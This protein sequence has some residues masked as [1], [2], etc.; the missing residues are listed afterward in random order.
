M[1]P[2]QFLDLVAQAG[3]L[4]DAELKTARA[5][6]ASSGAKLRA[7]DVAGI[8]VKKG[9]LTKN[10]AHRLLGQSIQADKGAEAAGPEAGKDRLK[11]TVS[12]RETVVEPPRPASPAAEEELG[13]APL[14]EE[15]GAIGPTA[16]AAKA[17]KPL[18]ATEEESLLASLE[19]D[20]EQAEKQPRGKRK[21]EEPKTGAAPAPAAPAP[22]APSP[23]LSSLGLEPLDQQAGLLPLDAAGG[24][25]PLD[26]TAGLQPLDALHGLEPLS[27]A[28]APGL[29]P[30]EG[31][32]P[33][34][35]EAAAPKKKRIKKSVW[36]S[37]LL[38]LGGGGLV[39]MLLLGVTL[40]YSLAR[41]SAG[42][43]FLAAEEDYKSQ[44]YGQAIAKYEKFL[45]AFPQDPNASAARV[46]IGT[47]RLWQSIEGGRDKQAALKLCGE[48]LPQIE[49]EPA[50][51]DIRGELATILPAIAE[52]FSLQ[53]KQ[54]EQDIAQA[55]AL[56]DLSQQ[57]MKLVNTA[58]YI[59]TSLRKSIES[60]LAAIQENIDTAQRNINRT[61]R[62]T[63]A[64]AEMQKAIAAGQTAAA[65]ET[66]RQLLKEY[67]ELEP[68]K[69]LVETVQQITAKERDL[70]KLDPQPLSATAEE[71]T[72]NVQF[73]VALASRRGPAAAPDGP[74]A[75]FL[76]S[77]AVYGLQATSGRLLWRRFVGHDTT[78][79]PL[80]IVSG[81]EADVVV[82]DS[83]RQELV[84]LKGASGALTWRLPVGEPLLP[85][86]LSGSR[87]LAATESGRLLVVEAAT[88]NATHQAV[89]PQ[90]LTVSPGV[91]KGQGVYQ[92]GSHSNLYVLD[93]TTLACQ[94]VY[95]LGH[96]AGT[97]AVPPMMVLGHL[98]IAENSGPAHCDLHVLAGDANGRELKPAKKSPLR[99]AGRVLVPPIVQGGRVIV[100]TDLGAVHVLEV[101]T[102]NPEQPVLNA[103]EPLPASFRTPVL[104]YGALD[105][106]RLWVGN[107]RLT[108]YE[109]QTS[110]N[111]LLT[112]WS[113]HERDTFVAPPQVVG[114]LVLHLRRRQHSPSFTA[115][116]VHV[117]DGKPIWETDLAAPPAL[118][119]VDMQRKQIHAIS[120]QAELF[121]VT[122]ETF[123]VGHLD[124]PASAAAGAARTVAFTDAIPVKNGMWALV[125]PQD[126]TQV[127][128]YNP[129]AVAAAG[130]L[131][132]RK[133]KALGDAQVS[134][135]PAPFAGGL[136]LP[137]DNGQLA[138]VD[139][140]TGDQQTAPFQSPTEAG[141][142]VQW[143]RAAVVGSGGT[144]LVIADSR[145]QLRRLGLQEGTP[146]RLAQRAQVELDA[147][148]VSPLAA[149]G[150]SVYG[151]VREANA[152]K[153]V[154][155]AAADLATGKEWPVE[156][157][158]TWGPEAVGDA[159]L[160]A[161][162][163]D[164]LLCFQT[165]QQQRWATKL[166]YGPL[167]G[168]PLPQ[169]SDLILTAL[170][171]V[172]WRVAAADG[173]ELRSG[174]TGEP[175]GGSAVPFGTRLLVPATDGTLHVIPAL[176]GS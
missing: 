96:K 71:V 64:V 92:V 60:R 40:Y 171:G 9:L 117:E 62:L 141:T 35:A 150:D 154:A 114:D 93:E 33:S 157:R 116:A 170:R 21:A 79:L 25:Q 63:A 115:A 90:P 146:P 43:M 83:A 137:L 74:P 111:K 129:A 130:R 22:P 55:Q 156:G 17:A 136:L 6:V 133:L 5:H 86:V 4:D 98:F 126:R 110:K 162:D 70:V 131:E 153:I 69:P 123:Q 88:G 54:Q 15:V 160:A 29:P 1:T 75:F 23:S 56:V 36:D 67:P 107:D 87:L 152:D 61:Q 7:K 34:P 52:A 76:A 119:A 39:L 24:L 41:G 151:V 138:V 145:R 118:V 149:A 101:N 8:L 44:A 26:A 73:E 121:E 122:P 132:A 20:E 109:I 68:R 28:Y 147:D 113:R 125:S 59:P 80:P 19:S 143:R 144:E 11:K 51:G 134:G 173:R 112:R 82:V 89:I 161:T 91:S 46:K 18:G 31:A 164:Q 176:P 166:P 12:P 159:V 97:V 32:K 128:L 47:A 85:P 106:G 2:E 105:S 3:L 16:A 148:V 95:Y 135:P 72:G 38:Y 30:A 50:F 99:L 65:Y 84:R 45:V 78:V 108:K 42:E 140:A 158:V 102:A 100:V 48:V 27:E 172:V 66:R 37:P 103:I 10:Q 57:A 13:L 169:D 14:D 167:V 165:G 139:P 124:Q 58:S 94:E 49:P 155:F 77:G 175:L 174:A 81:A 53:A 168:T 104:S 142:K 163:R 127:V 120:A